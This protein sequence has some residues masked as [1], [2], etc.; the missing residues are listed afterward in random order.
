M[1]KT[2]VAIAA[3]L[4]VLPPIAFTQNL[5][6]NPG[7]L[8]WKQINSPQQRIIFPPALDSQAKRIHHIASLLD[9]AKLFSLGSEQRKWNVVLLNQTTQSNA[10]V[11][12][13]PVMSE[14]YMNPSQDNFSLGSLRW[15]DNLVIHEQRH[16]HQF[17]NFNKGFTKVFSFLLG[18]EGQLLANGMTVP[19][20]FFEG[21]AVWQETA[22]SP[23]G[24][25][26]LPAFYNGLKA[27]WLANK[28]YSWMQ[29]RNG[30]LRNY[31]PDHY[32]IGYPLVAYG[33]AKYG[34][35]FWKKV[36]QDAVRFKGLFYAF[37]NAVKRHSG[38]S[39]PQF[40][41]DALK[42]FKD[43]VLPVQATEE[44]AQYLTPIVKN[45]VV[46]YLFPAYVGDDSILVT[47]RAYNEIN[48]FYLI[49]GGNEKRIRV[50]DLVTDDYFS[51]NNGKVVYAAFKSDARRT[52]K[53]YSDI[54]LLD[55]YSNK[56]RRL[57]SGAKYFSPDINAAGTEIIAV[58]VNA[59][60]TNFLH[61]IDA[62]TGKLIAQVPNPENYFF[63]QT[64]FLNAVEVVSAVRK[65]NGQMALVKVDLQNGAIQTLTPFSYNV[66]GYPSI[67][68]DT[69]YYSMMQA[70][71]SKNNTGRTV[72]DK[73]FAV[74]LK[75]GNNYQLSNNVNGY[76][77]P[78]ANKNGEILVSAFTAHGLRLVKLSR[79]PGALQPVDGVAGDDIS[80]VIISQRNFLADK[81]LDN[82]MVEPTTYKK[83]FR[84]FNFHSARPLVDGV[85][86]GYDFFGNNVLSTFSNTI[87]YRYNTNE[88]SSKL[89]YNLTYANLFP[90]LTA[91]VEYNFNRNIDT[92]IGSGINFNSV[93]A[94][95]GFYIPL[96]FV[97][98]RTIKN[99][100][101][102]GGYNVEQ[103]PYIGI[104]KNVLDNIAFKYANSFL[105]FSNAARRA[106][107]HINPRWAQA[108]SL[109]YR[110]GFN[111]FETGKFV[112]NSAFYFPGFSRNHSLV[113]NAAVQKR[114][115][116][117][118][119]FSNNFSYSRG[120][121]ALNTR[122]MYKIGANYHF[123]LFYP[124]WGLG[125]IFFIQ[126]IRANAFF[127][128]SNARARVNRVLTDIINRSTGGEIY[129]DSKI[130]NSLPVSIG[131]RYS[132]LLDT[133]LQNP[134]AT[135]RWE[136]ILPINIIPD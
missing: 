61:R 17:A 23:Q 78:V 38:I 130:W 134:R 99:L 36:T 96:R 89:G 20:Y 21:D 76:Y 41:K 15:D 64:K 63:T 107:Q 117:P 104:G 87:S 82:A 50:K 35:D 103:L 59:D 114:D 4:F 120:Y 55:I 116:F 111:Y 100:T 125:N 79:S 72:A 26:R 53:D 30:S 112:G 86:Y 71:G 127:D 123:P 94:N 131:V 115:T 90:F 133:D 73:I 52:N 42:Y 126:R 67:K 68:N 27:V 25:G 47:K 74:D 88:R 80:E 51:Y 92:A 98:G 136:I 62:G 95:L 24:R 56:H 7:K 91:G 28:K 83:S 44:A 93:K 77:Y 132:H 110:K 108:I 40:R 105:S 1:R 48:S 37:N 49:A 14:F 118:D 22:V 121:E 8:K 57:T 12:L 97:G 70:S 29:L 2:L 75:S 54:C 32:E 6:G 113:L 46:D 60:G 81:S 128:Y 101:F 43:R 33:Y 124:D 19:D 11:R 69:V 66:L 3:T 45:N 122:R 16:M 39:Y 5:G 10:Y 9:T 129:F 102:G 135:G 13:A 109:N 31:L 34:P 18:Q 119:F 58:N 106:R 85:E 84:L 65:A